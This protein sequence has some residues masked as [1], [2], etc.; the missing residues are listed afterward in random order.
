M[1]NRYK[2]AFRNVIRNKVFSTINIAGLAL[3]I[4]VFLLIMEFVAAEW[5]A[6]R[7]HKN[8]DRIYRVASASKEGT[9]YYLPP[10]YAPIVKEK[11]PSVEASVR[12][13]DGIGGGVIS[14]AEGTQDIKS[15]REEGILYVESNFFEVFS[16]PVIKGNP[17]LKSPNTLVLTEKMATKLLGSTDVAGKTVTVSNQFGNTPY[18]IAAVIQDMPQESDIK[19]NI[20]LSIHTLESA[21]N[22]DGNDW[23]DPNTVQSGFTNIYCQL[24]KNADGNS[25]AK[26]VTAFML[27]INPE[28]KGS[29]VIFQPMKYLHL[30]P[31]FSYPYQ[32]F[33][34]LPLVF[35]L[36]VVGLLIM[37]IAWV[38]YINLSTVQALTRAKESGVR[39]VLGATRFQ[40]V[41]QYLSE[42]IF[43]TLISVI[44]ALVMVQFLQ[45]LFNMF[46]GKTMSLS[47]LNFGWFWMMAVAVIVIGSFLSGGYVAFVLSSYKPIATIRGKIGKVGKG[48]TL[49]KGLVIFQFSI[50]IVFIIA[51]IILY[52][53]LSFMKTESLGMNL[54]QLIVIKGPTV[55]SENQ[56]E[57]NFVFKNQLRDLPF[58]KK[59]AASNNIPG[60]GYNFSTEGITRQSAN[61][62]DEKKK[63][64]MFIAD[65]NYFNTYQIAF[66]EGKSFS[67]EDANRSWNNARKVIINEKAAAQLGFTKGEPVVGK[68]ILW[69]EP[70]E[71]VGVVKDYHHLSLHQPI[72]AVIYLPSVSFGYFTIQTD[73]ANM[74]S[75]IS[76]IEKLYKTSFPGNPY[77]YFFAEESYD[78]QYKREQDLGSIFITAALIAIFI[79]C[80]GLF[81]LAAFS[82]RQRIKEIGIRKVLGAS[83]TDIAGLL[84]KDFI[85]LVLVSIVIATPIAWWGMHKWLQDFAYRTNIEWWVF[86]VAGFTAI[87]IAV[88]T[89]SL[90]AIRS[91][92]A[93][94]INS[95]RTE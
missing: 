65:E 82:A 1:F 93:N 42:T 28:A 39:K 68:K 46:S 16:F 64:N 81:G 66:A 62:G 22:R 70:Y 63:Y 51:T 26:Q 95:L 30:A 3:G 14:Y 20:F 13:A 2:I 57:K 73:Q 74:Q 34:S 50:S 40:L 45:P 69:G 35:M 79:A 12:V 76:T 7:F 91:A 75:K 48:I 6:N 9:N 77:E 72:E 59:V 29:E 53:Q 67:Q 89:V 18:T 25:V 88:V 8:F 80:L 19:G 55:S 83:V 33:G 52:K 47:A 92:L 37:L 23:A 44:I 61:P 41:G 17:S 90:Q 84:S 15:F 21:A 54:D 36:M 78:Q 94:P 11:F 4:A 71:V 49:R 10:G 32:T 24:Q 58:V 85:K 38:N 56:A 31:D 87:F 27:S 60:Q 86:I 43:L 5:G